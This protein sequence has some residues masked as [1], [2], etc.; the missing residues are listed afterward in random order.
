[1]SK[2]TRSIGLAFLFS[3]LMVT[4]VAVAANILFATEVAATACHQ[5][6]TLACVL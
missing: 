5:A 6:Y 3:L 4:S 2:D 1:M